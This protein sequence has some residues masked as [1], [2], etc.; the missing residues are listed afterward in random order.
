MLGTHTLEDKMLIF[1]LGTHTLEDKML[2][3]ML[4]THTLVDTSS[5]S[6]QVNIP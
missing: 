2:I 6:C 5:F 3:F 4:G 1:M